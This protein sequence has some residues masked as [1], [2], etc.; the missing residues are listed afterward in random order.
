MRTFE[1][2]AAKP[3]VDLPLYSSLPLV[4]SPA[5]AGLLAAVRGLGSSVARAL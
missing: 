2:Y 4:L 5:H 3:A 1:R